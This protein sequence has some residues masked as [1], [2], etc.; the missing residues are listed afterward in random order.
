MKKIIVLYSLALMLLISGEMAHSQTTGSK[1]PVTQLKSSDKIKKGSK[2]DNDNSFKSTK[3]VNSTSSNGYNIVMGP[4]PTPI[5]WENFEDSNGNYHFYIGGVEYVISSEESERIFS[6]STCFRAGS[7]GFVLKIAPISLGE[8]TGTPPSTTLNRRF[9][10]FISVVKGKTYSVRFKAAADSARTIDVLCTQKF[11]PFDTALWVREI[12]LD[13][14][15]TTYGSYLLNWGQNVIQKTTAISTSNNKSLAL[16][17]DESL[18][19]S[20][21]FMFA[22]GASLIPVYL[23]DIEIIEVSAPE[24]NVVQEDSIIEDNSGI[25]DFGDVEVGSSKSVLFTIEN[26]G[27]ASLKLSEGTTK[28]TVLSEDGFTLKTDAVSPVACGNS[29]TFE[30]LFEP[31]SIGDA[32]GTISIENNDASE[33]PYNFT[34]VG[35]GVNTTATVEIDDINRDIKIYPNPASQDMNISFTSAPNIYSIE[36]YNNLGQ[37]V[38]QKQSTY[39]VEKLDLKNLNS[40][41]YYLNIFNNDFS[42]TEKIIVR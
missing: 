14:T 29:T 15:L 1:F 9:G 32:T 12:P 39:Q 23:D 36:L 41:I 38:L 19:D 42:R 40:G 20:L 6:T 31:T 30:V 4:P 3:I 17:S 8:P 2:I 27:T 7:A 18:T 16:F 22:V 13:T 37:L 33:N 5:Y 26:T 11:A 28:V 35:L 24:I 10:T 25:Y 34:I 21:D